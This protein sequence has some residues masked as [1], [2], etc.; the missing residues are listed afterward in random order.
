V[1]K[2]NLKKFVTRLELS[3]KII[4][5]PQHD[6]PIEVI[7]EDLEPESETS[8]ETRQGKPPEDR[9]SQGKA[10]EDGSDAPLPIH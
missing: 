2:A 1:A 6:T 10:P 7:P 5:G 4:D 8:V 9:V 3:E